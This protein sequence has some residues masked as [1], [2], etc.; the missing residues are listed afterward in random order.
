MI[1]SSNAGIL[2]GTEIWTHPVSQG[3]FSIEAQKEQIAFI[4]SAFG[5]KFYLLPGPDG[6]RALSPYQ[7][8][9]LFW[10]LFLSGSESTGLT[11]LAIYY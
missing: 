8:Y 9:G 7:R 1:S 6:I 5:W 3:C 11:C 2:P 4:Y 10:P